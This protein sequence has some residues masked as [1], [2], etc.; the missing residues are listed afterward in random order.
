MDQAPEPDDRNDIGHPAGCF[1]PACLPEEYDNAYLQ[2]VSTGAASR[3][4]SDYWALPHQ[5]SR[6]HR[7]SPA[8]RFTART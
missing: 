3:N 7:A 8:E 1:C 2:T 4:R 6:V 5:P